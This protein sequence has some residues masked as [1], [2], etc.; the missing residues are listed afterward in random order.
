MTLEQKISLLLLSF[1][2]LLGS[3]CQKRPDPLVH[4]R[5]KFDPLQERLNANG[6]PSGITAGRAAQTPLVN[7]IGVQQIELATGNLIAAGKGVILFST[8]TTIAG[9]ETAVD[10]GQLKLVKDGEI[11]FSIPMSQIGIGSY[12]W[13]R[14]AVAYQNFHVQFNMTNVPFSGSFN[15]E[16][17]TFATFL[18]S[19]NYITKYR[20][21]TK[22]ETVNANRKQGYWSFETKLASAY[23]SNDRIYNGQAIESP[24]MVNPLS[25]TSPLPTGSCLVTGRFDTPLSITGKETQDVTVTLSFSTNRSFEWEESVTRNGKWDADRQ[26]NT[27]QPAIE[28]VVDAGF[29]G[30]RVWYENR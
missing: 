9:G 19:N 15:D 29:R 5:V 1:V 23:S 30:L 8:P 24:T 18:A 21:G 28:R 13:V 3:S 14:V 10:F 26:A 16:R 4:F 11:M 7:V 25:Q 17:G 2:V 12:D 20:I 27:G 22:D 6:L